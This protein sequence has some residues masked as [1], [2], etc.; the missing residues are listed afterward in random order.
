MRP[1]I[2][3]TVAVL[4]GF[5]LIFFFI[6]CTPYTTDSRESGF[7][8][9]QKSFNALNETPSLHEVVTLGDV[10][11]HIVGHRRYFH[12]DKATAFESGIIGYANRKNEIWL[13]GRIV[14]GRIVINQAVLGHE[15]NHLLNFKNY[16]IA[17]PDRLD[18]LEYCDAYAKRC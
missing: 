8:M 6:G 13:L 9:I 15:L 4:I 1:Q 11:V 12:W 18:R 16:N 2:Q 7:R 5:G 17:N 14:N 10:K 3:N